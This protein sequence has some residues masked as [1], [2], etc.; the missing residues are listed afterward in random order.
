MRPDQGPPP[1]NEATEATY[2]DL[3]GL[4]RDVQRRQEPQPLGCHPNGRETVAFIHSLIAASD[5][6]DSSTE[7]CIRDDVHIIG[8]EEKLADEHIFPS[9]FNCYGL[10]SSAEGTYFLGEN[11]N[12][13]LYAFR[14]RTQWLDNHPDIVVHS[15]PSLDRPVLATCSYLTH[16]R[17]IWEVGLPYAEPGTGGASSC[18]VITGGADW[19]RPAFCFS[20]ETPL[21]SHKE[22]FEWRFSGNPNIK[23]LL[24]GDMYGW[25]LVRITSDMATAESG[26]GAKGTTLRT[27][28]GKEVVALCSAN[29]FSWTKY[30]KFMFLGTGKRRVL[31]AR[32]EA[33]VAVT[34]LMLMDWDL[35]KR[36][37]D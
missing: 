37:G 27:T 30:W 11:Q 4:Y 33:V 36:N 16:R 17:Q 2:D 9:S 8:P 35:K 26:R 3:I 24:G 20:I 5:S 6:S 23:K 19:K 32:W 25:K 15:G 28:D 10:S 34:S 22:R 21:S 13:P 18:V 7:T 29:G 12:A 14:R 1:Y 31:G